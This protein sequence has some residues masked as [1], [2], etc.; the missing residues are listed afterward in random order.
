MK[1]P[2]ILLFHRFRVVIGSDGLC[3]V[4]VSLLVLVFLQ[5]GLTGVDQQYKV[6]CLSA[7]PPPPPPPKK[8]HTHTHIHTYT[9]AR[10][11]SFGIWDSWRTCC[12]R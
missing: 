10:A 1:P 11:P 12:K 6:P 4:I 2:V 7:T 5:S 3:V 9:R 8:K